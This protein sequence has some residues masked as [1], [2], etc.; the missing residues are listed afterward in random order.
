MFKKIL[1]GIALIVILV[2]VLSLTKP[3]SYTVVRSTTIQAPPEAV[4]AYLDDFHE[5]DAWSP[6]EK[7]DPAM[8]RT[9]EGPSSG[10]GAVYTW[11]GNSQVGKGRMEITN[12]SPPSA[13][14]INL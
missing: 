9:Y 14:N 8:K 1:I 4:Y 5:W 3:N 10:K 11:Q 13:V 12:A 6:W 2:L 7:M